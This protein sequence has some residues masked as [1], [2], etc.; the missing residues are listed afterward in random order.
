MFVEAGWSCLGHWTRGGGYILQSTIYIGRGT[1]HAHVRFMYSCTALSAVRYSVGLERRGGR[2]GARD[3]SLGRP[4]A[5]GNPPAVRPQRGV[6]F[7]ACSPFAG[8]LGQKFLE[9]I[10]FGRKRQ[11]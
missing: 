1:V 10:S 3:S 6:G 7:C 11:D 8:C 4:T 2:G 5:G 9:S